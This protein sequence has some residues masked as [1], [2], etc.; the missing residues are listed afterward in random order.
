M[1]C[2]FSI[3]NLTFH[4]FW[5]KFLYFLVLIWR[6]MKVNGNYFPWSTENELFRVVN[7]SSFRRWKTFF[8]A[9]LSRGNLD[10]PH[11]NSNNLFLLS[12]SLSL[13]LSHPCNHHTPTPHKT[14]NP[15]PQLPVC[16]C[17]ISSPHPPCY[18]H[19]LKPWH[20]SLIPSHHCHP[21]MM[22]PRKGGQKRKK[23]KRRE[24]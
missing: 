15:N 18:I 1:C 6:T 11:T 4:L 22:L 13:S 10:A 23:E 16:K 20:P 21:M 5:W 17:H 19:W 8:W 9:N 24:M 14:P 7:V 3:C 12:L 2:G